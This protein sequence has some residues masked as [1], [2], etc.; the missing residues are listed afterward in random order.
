MKCHYCGQPLAK[1]DAHDLRVKR[2]VYR[3]VRL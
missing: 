3:L 1:H 2:P